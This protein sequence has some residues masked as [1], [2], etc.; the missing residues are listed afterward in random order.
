MTGKELVQH[1]KDVQDYID[2]G[3]VETF[4]LTIDTVAPCLIS[5]HRGMF[6]DEYVKLSEYA[7]VLK[8]QID[9]ER[10]EG[11]LDTA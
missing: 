10:L 4:H 11:N 2:R 5:R 7:A 3:V 8:K 6:S 1:H 9:A